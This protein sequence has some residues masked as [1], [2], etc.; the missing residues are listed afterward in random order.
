MIKKIFTKKQFLRV[1]KYGK[2]KRGSKRNKKISDKVI[3]GE[4]VDISGFCRI[5]KAFTKFYLDSL[6]LHNGIV[7]FKERMVCPNCG[8]N[9]RQRFLLER[10]LKASKKYTDCQIYIY[11]Q[12]TPFYNVIK[13]IYPKITGSEYLGAEY[14]SGTVVNGIRHED[15]TCLSFSDNSF[16][17]V[18][19]LDVFEHIF[20]LEKGFKEAF[21]ILKPR[22]KMTFSIPFY[23]LNNTTQKRAEITDGK[24]I[25]LKEPQYHGNPVSEKGSLVVYDISWDCFDV[26][27]KCGFSKVYMVAG[28][29]RLT[30]NIGDPL[31][32]F[33][34]AIKGP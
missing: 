18:L 28:Y 7:N 15:S 2:L 11:E 19:S 20:D 13:K 27:K 25:F 8:L 4:L 12:V 29:N 6:W 30:G 26:I 14:S 34:E 5:C 31:Q 9:N 10:V 24:I 17:L 23:P 21:R 32:F 33:F 22:G 16:D 3:N 1:L